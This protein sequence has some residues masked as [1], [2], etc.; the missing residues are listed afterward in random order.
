MKRDV[1]VKDRLDAAKV[2]PG[3]PTLEDENEGEQD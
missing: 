2:L 1:P 3:L